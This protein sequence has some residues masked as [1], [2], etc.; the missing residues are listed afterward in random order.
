M[1]KASRKKKSES[2][3]GSPPKGSLR[4]TA[5]MVTI[6]PI[7]ILL[8]VSFAAYFNSLFGDF[9]Y[10]DKQQ[11][12][13]N[14]WIRHIS[15]IPTIFSRS[16]WSFQPGLS[17]W[18]YYRPLMH[19]VYMFNYYVFG[20]DPSG[21]HLVN[22]LFHCG[23]SV[24]VFL[25]IRKL[26]AGH[27]VRTSSIYL[28]PPFIAA[29]LF[30]LDPIHTEAIS[31]IAGL[32]EVSFT[33]FYLLSLYSYI[34]F[35]DGAKRGY[36]LSIVS[37]SVATL[38]KEPALTL[39]VMLIAYDYLFKKFDRTLFAGIKRYMP[40]IAI[41]GIYLIV[42]HYALGGLVPVK[43]YAELNTNQFIINVFPLFREYLTSLLW[44]FNL[45]FWH[46]FHPISTLFEANG[47]ISAVATA[48]FVVAALAAY[49][50]NKILFFGLLLLIVPLLPAF[51]IKGISGKP[52][53]ERYLYLPSV[54]YVLILAILLSWAR[55]KLPRAAGGIM[56]A[57]AV[58]AG[59]YVV[60]TINRNDVWKDDFHLWSDTAKKSADCAIA[61]NELARAYAS[62]G[63]LD[64]AI[65]ELHAALR[66]EPDSEKAHVSLGNIYE[67]RGQYDEA[68]AEFQTALRLKPDNEI[69]RS[70]LA[71][72]QA[73]Q[74]KGDGQRGV[75]APSRE[76]P[77]SAGAHLSLAM[78]YVS[79]GQLDKAIAELQTALRLKP[80]SVIAHVGLGNAYASR[81]QADRAIAEFQEALLLAP[82]SAIAH[83]GLG[84][85]YLSKGQ[86]DR[87]IEEFQA[88][89]R[90]K[91]DSAIGSA[92]A[93]VGLGNAYAYKGQSDRAIAEFQEALRLKP[94]FGEAR[95]RLNDLKRHKSP[96]A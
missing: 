46:T 28:S 86:P 15:N 53:A 67:A 36:L 14:P 69:A 8:A 70:N 38:F 82:D 63:Q 31:W 93:H 41:S 3:R 34:L 81:G 66:L 23:T 18:N 13:D 10:D 5:S 95:Q 62:Q 21:F 33:F 73:S 89:L 20:L 77:D 6:F 58:L 42:R 75:T 30:A 44:P 29:L 19:V 71:R 48:V 61:H 88:A 2:L 87:A 9:V 11:I 68:V 26:L 45:N 32:P 4:K 51:Y 7:L 91:P 35:R 84:N 65:A 37:F 92:I 39:P 79:K 90:L 80:D 49:K 50:K 85:G 24:L 59:L 60:V 27:Q 52:Y 25:I 55:D 72:V 83:V 78:A 1:G 74:R 57:F 16:V 64:G 40:F 22:I 47:V 76:K 54:G 17:T 94:D 43:A 12:V 56:M 96:P